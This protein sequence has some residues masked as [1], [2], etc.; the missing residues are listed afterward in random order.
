MY[1]W[2]TANLDLA[3]IIALYL[4][5]YVVVKHF[6]KTFLIRQAKKRS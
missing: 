2:V 1:N 5:G 4:I 6:L 3:G